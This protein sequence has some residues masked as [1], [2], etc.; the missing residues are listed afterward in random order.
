[1]NISSL[2]KTLAAT[3]LLGF[4]VKANAQETKAE[5]IFGTVV[6]KKKT[7]DST[8]KKPTFNPLKPAFL[9]IGIMGG[10]LFSFDNANTDKTGGTAGLRVEYGFSNRIS[11]V[12]EMQGN[13]F[14]NGNTAF[15]RS[16]AS[17]GIN[18]MPF[19]TKRLQPYFGAGGGVGFSFDRYGNGRRG[20]DRLFDNDNNSRER[21]GFL[22]ARTGLN[23]VLMKRIIA[24]VET[25]YQLPVGNATT[26]NGGLAL[27]AGV[28]YQFGGAKK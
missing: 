22:F 1:M 15:E 13:G 4:F 12:G 2:K 21:Q 19:K 9:R 27:R 24:T 25:S 17:L 26:S 8:K 23:Y 28:S 7:T 10:G 5:P 6:E 3:A 18:W 20:W 11:L 14:F 16:Q